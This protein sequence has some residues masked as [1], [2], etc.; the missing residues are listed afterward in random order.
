MGTHAKGQNT[1][2]ATC[3]DCDRRLE[4]G[5]GLVYEV[6]DYP[7]DGS[8]AEGSIMKK[9]ESYTICQNRTIC[10]RRVVEQGNNIEVLRRIARDYENLG[11]LATEAKRILAEYRDVV[12]GIAR[13]NDAAAREGG[14]GVIGGPRGRH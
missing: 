6:W 11:E 3:R 12:L 9:L 1:R 13:A 2:K 14:W 5:E 8:D 10:A 4:P 7:W